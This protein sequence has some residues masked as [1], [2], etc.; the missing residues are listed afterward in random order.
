MQKQGNR[1]DCSYIHSM[2]IQCDRC[3]LKRTT[4]A[5]GANKFGCVIKFHHS[6]LR[7]GNVLFGMFCFA[8]CIFLDSTAT[9]TYGAFTLLNLTR[10]KFK[11]LQSALW[12][13]GGSLAATHWRPILT[14]LSAQTAACGWVSMSP[15]C[16]V[17]SVTIFDCWLQRCTVCIISSL[18]KYTRSCPRLSWL[19]YDNVDILQSNI[20]HSTALLVSVCLEKVIN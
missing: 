3:P 4:A 19:N 7:Y 1:G 5:L 15:K 14:C 9:R 18:V 20:L 17:S 13:S 16:V 6:P 2:F 12:M 8:S 10:E 11:V